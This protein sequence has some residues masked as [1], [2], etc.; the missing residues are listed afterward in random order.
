MINLHGS[1]WAPGTSRTRQIQTAALAP[2]QRHAVTRQEEYERFSKLLFR[3]E[4]KANHLLISQQ[5]VL[6]HH[7]PNVTAGWLFTST[8][9]EAETMFKVDFFEFYILLERSI[10]HL[11]AVFTIV[12]SASTAFEVNEEDTS[13]ASGPQI[14]GD[15]RV[16]NRATHSYHEN[17]LKALDQATNPLHNILGSGQVREY[18]SIAKEFRNRW[19]DAEE[20]PPSSSSPDRNDRRQRRY[21]RLLREL[22]LEEMLN[23]LLLALKA[24]KQ[25]AEQECVRVGSVNAS[26][27]QRGRMG[28]TQQPWESMPDAM[29]WD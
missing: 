14:F 15:G 12:V 16:F 3:L 1:R 7:D 28:E 26:V 10:I 8:P 17:V 23:C 4:W 5:Q 2:E 18:L 9:T 13:V 24:A 29:D 11:L 21:E 6:V 25:V 27:G 20:R 19:K 22:K